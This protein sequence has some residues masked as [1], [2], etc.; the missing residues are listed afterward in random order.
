MRAGQTVRRGE[1]IAVEGNTGY[2]LPRPTSAVDKESCRHLHFEVRKNGA[3]VDPTSLIGIQNRVG[4]YEVKDDANDADF[5]CGV[6]GLEAQTRAYID[7][8]RFAAELWRKLAE[9]MR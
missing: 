3:A 6:C 5:V 7:R 8:Y 1:E 2:V 9:A 4:T